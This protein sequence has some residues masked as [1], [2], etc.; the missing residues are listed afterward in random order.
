MI[1]VGDGLA[2]QKMLDPDNVDLPGLFALWAE[3]MRPALARMLAADG[4]A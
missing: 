3:I 2:L 1:A 4:D